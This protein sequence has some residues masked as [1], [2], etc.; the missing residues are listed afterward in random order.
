MSSY[1]KESTLAKLVNKQIVSWERAKKP[2]EEKL[3]ELPRPFITISREYGCDCTTICNI[4]AQKL[5][6]YE[7]IEEWQTY[8]KELINKIVEDHQISETLIQTIDTKKR[9]EISE[10]MRSMLTDYPPQVTV[11]KKLVQTI[12]S[13]SVMGRSIIVGRAGVVITKG[14]KYGVHV[15][16]VA[17]FSNRVRKIMELN[18]IKDKGEAE[19]LVE[20]KDR[21]RHSFLTQ[22]IKFDA[23]D[24]VSYDVTINIARFSPE[25]VADIIIGILK[26][27]GFTK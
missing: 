17:P 16:F 1:V 14:L 2:L 4:I 8:D 5:N 13:L 12:R 15:K 27:K 22:Y 21:E 9:E 23:K 7:N 10:L 26:A 19:R 24:P 6:E 18:G 3:D 20:N 11:Y 25:Q